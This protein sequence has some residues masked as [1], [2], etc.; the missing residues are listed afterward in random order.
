MSRSVT[1]GRLC[2]F[3]PPAEWES[4]WSAAGGNREGVSSPARSCVR[5]DSALGGGAFGTPRDIRQPEDN[6]SPG[7]LQGGN[8]V[9]LSLLVS[10]ME[11]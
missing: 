2:H 10:R 1:A 4:P 11:R 9:N 5:S 7:E 8:E 6:L 3:P